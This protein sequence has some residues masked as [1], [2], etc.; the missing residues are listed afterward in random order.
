MVLQAQVE[1]LPFEDASFDTVVS[2]LVL[3]S[4]TDVARMLAEIRRVLRPAGC[5][6]FLEHGGAVEPG[7]AGWQR[8]LEPVWK[9]VA[10]GCHLT[11]DAAAL[12]EGAGFTIDEV[13][14]HHP[15]RTGPMKPFRVGVAHASG[16]A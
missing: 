11:R 13:H 10:G 14:D 2:T 15:A 7:V 6:R 12:I 16:I 9:R 8:R 4:V 3:C 1:T 5:Y